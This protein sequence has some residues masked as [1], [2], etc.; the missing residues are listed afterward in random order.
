MR[1]RQLFTMLFLFCAFRCEPFVWL[2][3]CSVEQTYMDNTATYSVEVVDNTSNIMIIY[4]EPKPF[5]VQGQQYFY[6][7]R[8]FEFPF[9]KW[10]H[11]GANFE[12]MSNYPYTS[13]R[14]FG[15]L[16]MGSSAQLFFQPRGGN[17]QD[18]KQVNCKLFTKNGEVEPGILLNSSDPFDN[19]T[20]NKQDLIQMRRLLLI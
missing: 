11:G 5:D 19:G 15:Q 2:N 4:I 1:T 9:I 10:Q 7:V 20:L 17:P 3:D 6:Q 18:Q 12:D 16:E 13:I 8:R 14:M